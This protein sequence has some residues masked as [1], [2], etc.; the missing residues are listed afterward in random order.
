VSAPVGLA[1]IDKTSATAG[2]VQ[3]TIN[4]NV[5]SVNYVEVAVGL[6]SAVADPIAFT[7]THG[8]RL[9]Q[10]N[11]TTTL[12]SSLGWDGPPVAISRAGAARFRLTVPLRTVY[13]RAA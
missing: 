1:L 7:Q 10:F 9:V 12:V 3:K 11:G 6:R 5:S 13:R 4:I 2:S 8:L